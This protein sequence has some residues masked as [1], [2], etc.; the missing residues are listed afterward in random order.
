MTV[1]RMPFVVRCIC[2]V[3]AGLAPLVASQ[4]HALAAPGADL[5]SAGVAPGS[6]TDATGGFFLLDLAPGDTAMQYVVITN[7]NAK[8]V[9]ADISGVDAWTAARTGA[10]YGTPGSQPAA[11]GRWISVNERQIQLAPGERRTVGFRVQVPDNALPGQHLAGVSIS[12]PLD[13]ASMSSKP[14]A[15]QAAFDVALQ[16]QR[17]IAVE[18]DIAGERAP[19]LAVL[20]A[21]PVAHGDMIDLELAIANKGNAFARGHGVLAVPDTGLRFEFPIDTFVPHTSIKMLVPWTRNARSGDHKVDA[22]LTY[23]D[24]KR[25][26]WSGVVSI[27]EALRSELDGQLH[28]AEPTSGHN[29]AAAGISAITVGGGAVGVATCSAL[30]I[31]LRRR[32]NLVANGARV[33][34]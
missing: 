29:E 8:S 5:V 33:R 28:A 21:R 9:L 19:D 10:S 26:T 25:A 22:V 15:N 18:I 12:V 32:R 3:V 2:V 27:D 7:P 31:R 24:G 23:D 20:G 6:Q 14:G 17:V 4:P 16:P 34:D 30:A 13:T 1:L 11:T